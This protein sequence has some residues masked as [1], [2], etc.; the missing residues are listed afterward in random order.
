[1]LYATEL[2][3]KSLQFTALYS[4]LNFVFTLYLQEEWNSM[5]S[6]YLGKSE[7]I[8]KNYDNQT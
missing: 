3:N 4:I 1:M 8:L 5:C 2:Y 7:M 6:E